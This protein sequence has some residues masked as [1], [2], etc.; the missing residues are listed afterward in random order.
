MENRVSLSDPGY[1]QAP[2][3]LN[4]KGVKHAFF[5]RQGGVSQG[6]YA[7][8]NGGLGSSDNADHVSENRK[9]MAHIV[10]VRPDLLLSLY[11]VH[12]PHVVTIREQSDVWTLDERPKADAMVTNVK[13]LA[14]GVASA[15][16]GPVLFADGQAGVV[17]AAHSGWKGSLGGV[18]EATLNAMEELGAK[19]ARIRAILGPT[20]S[21]N[22]YEVGEDFIN[23]FTNEDPWNRDFF[24][25]RG[26]KQTPHFDLPAYIRHRLEKAG[27]GVFADLGKCTYSDEVRFFSYRRSVHRH[28]MDYGRLISAIA[29]EAPIEPLKTTNQF[30]PIPVSPLRF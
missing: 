1:L 12:S 26:P 2:A 14:L 23:N 8:L 22:A 24:A 20:I 27:V 4:I 30:N 19:R 6:L 11:Q 21:R 10:G 29:L 7:S 9:R 15:D 3:L 5:T 25:D 18:L 17:G 28:E 13:G 16:C